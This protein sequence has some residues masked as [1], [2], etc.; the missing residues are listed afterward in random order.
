MWLRTT[1]KSNG[2]VGSSGAM[3][4]SR[5]CN[6]Q[7]ANTMLQDTSTNN[8]NYNEDRKRKNSGIKSVEEG[9]PFYE[10]QQQWESFKEALYS[11]EPFDQ[12]HWL[13]VLFRAFVGYLV[14]SVQRTLLPPSVKR[15]S[16]VI[17]PCFALSLVAS[18]LCLYFLVL[19]KQVIL[20][21]WCGTANTATCRWAYFHDTLVIYLGFMILWNYLIT[22]LSSPGVALPHK[23]SS[24]TGNNTQERLVWKSSEGRGGCCFVNPFPVNV[25]LELS[26]VQRFMPPSAR[27]L[28]S[29]TTT[30]DTTIDCIVGGHQRQNQIETTSNKYTDSHDQKIIIHFPSLEPSACEKCHIGNRPPRCHHC[31]TCNRCVLQMDHHC[32]WMNT[33]IGYGNY[34]NFILTLVYVMLACIYGTIML[35][36]PFRELLQVQVAQHGFW[37]TL[38]NLR[39]PPLWVLV[40]KAFYS[41]YTD[42]DGSQHHAIDGN[43]ALKVAFPFLLGVSLTMIV[44]L[45]FHLWLISKGMTTLERMIQLERM[46]TILQSSMSKIDP[47]VVVN[48]YNQGFQK[49]AYQIFGRNFLFLLLPVYVEPPQPYLPPLQESGVQSKKDI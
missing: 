15:V 38:W 19:R 4:N 30:A 34:R 45:S 22:V 44:F 18:M 17:I 26:R 35:V 46:K 14:I 2:K 49:N 28:L 32:I 12:W 1:Q 16:K 6:A 3:H 10:L 24:I 23:E 31:S 11:V 9:D 39:I 41:S 20:P 29:N 21:R 37:T 25:E 43:V 47:I 48:P 42:D 13:Y 40:S 27:S 36:F 8:H 5:I 33:C 7:S